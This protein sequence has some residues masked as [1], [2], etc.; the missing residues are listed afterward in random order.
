[1]SATSN[2]L[3]V[4]L[5][6]PSDVLEERE[7][8]DDVIATVNKT[9]RRLG[10]F[11][12]LH[13][14]EDSPPGFG[15]PQ[16]QINP[17]VDECDLF[18]GLLWQRWGQPSGQYPSGFEEEYERA[19]ARRRDSGRPD[20]W[21][22]FKEVDPDKLNDPGEQLKNVVEFR[23]AQARINEVLFKQVR[24]GNEW[25]N[26]LQ[27]WLTE[28]VLSLFIP[29]SSTQGEPPSALPPVQTTDLTVS[30]AKL[31]PPSQPIPAQLKSLSVSL[32][33]AL[34]NTSAA[35]FADDTGVLAEFEVA[36]LSL[37]VSTLLSRRHTSE[38]MDT[39][40][41]NL[42]YKHR[43][44]LDTTYEE[45][46]QLFRTI[47]EDPSQV[48]PGWYWFRNISEDALPTTLLSFAHHGWSE[49]V[50]IRALEL[51]TSTQSMI[52]KELWPALPLF[53]DSLRVRQKAFE[54]VGAVGND[55][56]LT[57]LQKIAD[58]DDSRLSALIRS[59]RLRIISRLDP[60]RG[61]SEIVDSKGDV[62]KED[63]EVIL[64]P[65]SKVATQILLRGVACSIESIK[66][67]SIKE[68][69][70]RRE[71]PTELAKQL[72]KDESLTV[73]ALAFQSLALEGAL[74][75]VESVREALKER[76]AS[77][78]S[79][80]LS[81]LL[82]GRTSESMPDVESIILDFFQ[83]QSTEQLLSAVD[84]FS[85]QGHLAYEALALDRFDVISA[86]IRSDLTEGFKRIRDESSRRAELEYGE[87]G[88]KT[89][90]AAF[91]KFDGFVRSLFPKSGAF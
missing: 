2:V 28:Y 69:V 22:V 24:D 40:H 20:I 75:D 89:L 13:R 44:E 48:K 31:Q 14:W 85:L 19:T 72:A 62:S 7:I 76:D 43:R 27:T 35:L 25:R 52:P 47:I 39:H 21:L 84:W 6:S 59:T 34:R 91:E 11:I 60:D 17:M 78:N 70:H 50:T 49:A 15:R 58:P 53:D 51:L 57:F 42:L 64:A 18:I 71:L 26:R 55:A 88:S 65:I 67:A 3:R 63:V 4:F 74:P 8:A 33:K 83:T 68:L 29:P 45:K 86:H 23:T 32:G 37:L 30:D 66:K 54:Y 79:I 81:A 61:F 36:R 73:R 10:W 41:I 16:A 80:R 1:M 9:V 5:A 46:S 82:G 12:D 90:I 56:T 87:A 77:P 38:V